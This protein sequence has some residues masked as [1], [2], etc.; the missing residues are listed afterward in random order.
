MFSSLGNAFGAVVGSAFGNKLGRKI[1]KPQSAWNIDDA[2]EAQALENEGYAWRDQYDWQRAKERGLTLPEFYGSPASGGSS[3]AGQGAVLGNSAQQAQSDKTRQYG[4][5]VQRGLDRATQLKQTEMQTDAQKEVAKI[6]SGATLGAAKIS[7]EVQE[8]RNQIEQGKLDLSKDNYRYILLPAAAAQLKISAAE[9]DLK[10]N[11]IANTRHEWV[12]EKTLLQMGVDNTI[13]TLIL[14]R[15]GK[16]ITKAS[17]V[18]SM[19]Q[20]EFKST[21]S[22]LLAAKSAIQVN[23]EGVLQTIDNMVGAAKSKAAQFVEGMK[24]PSNKK[25]PRQAGPFYT[26]PNMNER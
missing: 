26:H 25:G 24:F 4:E 12:R 6:Q 7:A 10:L 13:Q 17:D 11:E 14:K 8:V 20:Q 21:L 1:D 22:S 23:A 19:S 9:L 5:A 16:D 18:R 15:T 3:P 2:R